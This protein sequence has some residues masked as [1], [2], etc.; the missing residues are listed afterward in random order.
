MSAFLKQLVYVLREN[1]VTLM[2]FVLF[3]AFCFVALFGPLIAP[4]RSPR[5]RYS[6]RIAGSIRCAGSPPHQLSAL[7]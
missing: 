6:Q 1:P 2:A 7:S 4:L 5:E 3:S